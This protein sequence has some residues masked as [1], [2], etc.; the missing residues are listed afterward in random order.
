MFLHCEEKNGILFVTNEN[1]GIT[2][3]RKDRSVISGVM[4]STG[5]GL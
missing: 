4:G 1:K 3:E 2:D 5:R